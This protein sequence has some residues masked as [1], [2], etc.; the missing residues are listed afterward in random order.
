MN[1][2]GNC[3]R[4]APFSIAT[5]PMSTEGFLSFLWIAPLTHDTYLI[6]LSVKQGGIKY[7]FLR[8]WYDSTRDRIPVT[9]V[10]GEY[11]TYIYIYI[12]I[13]RY[14]WFGLI[15]W[16]INPFCGDQGSIAIMRKSKRNN[17]WKQC[18]FF[19]CIIEHL[20]DFYN[21]GCWIYKIN[22]M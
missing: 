6:V 20:F 3:R 13:Y 22:L 19:K 8:L 10:I 12:Y 2:V 9:C 1:K 18:V 14:V 21:N 15:L 17:S 4:K 5:S 11:S 7:H 16:H